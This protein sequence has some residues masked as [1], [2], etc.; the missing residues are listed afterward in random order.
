V[1]TDNYTLDE[2]V[3][4]G[5]LVPPKAVSVPLLFQREGISYDQLQK[6]KKKNGTR[7]IGV[8]R[9]VPNEN[10]IYLDFRCPVTS[11]AFAPR[12]ASSLRR[13]KTTL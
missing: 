11:S 9:W 7:S 10:S 6:K 13:M 1:P 8:T 5:F 12:R 2:A 4:D 3:S